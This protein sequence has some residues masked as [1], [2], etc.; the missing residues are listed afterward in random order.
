MLGE[1]YLNSPYAKF[2][3]N[4]DISITIYFSVTIRIL[5][6]KGEFGFKIPLNS[7]W[8]EKVSICLQNCNC[9]TVWREVW[10][11]QGL[12][13]PLGK[14]GIVTQRG[15]MVGRAKMRI[16]MQRIREC[17]AFPTQAKPPTFLLR[18]LGYSKTELTQ[19]KSGRSEFLNHYVEHIFS[20]FK[21]VIKAVFAI[22]GFF[23][24]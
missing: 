14:Q 12:C 15:P 11:V 9:F 13:Q 23:N 21:L 3:G 10:A 1:F 18:Y 7:S 5:L 16:T 19:R 24:I 22:L 8:Q 6:F 2:H 4:C 17:P 20:L